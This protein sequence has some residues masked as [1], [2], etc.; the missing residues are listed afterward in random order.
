MWC[1][2]LGP[3]LGLFFPEFFVPVFFGK[4]SI[5]SFNE[6]I[7]FEAEVPKVRNRALKSF[8][9]PRPSTPLIPLVFP[10]VP[11]PTKGRPAAVHRAQ[12]HGRN[13]PRLRH[14]AVVSPSVCLLVAPCAGLG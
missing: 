3:D 14:V 12:R 4:N 8:G 10:L 2:I 5:I 7:L 13:A 11:H 9:P 1:C 6:L